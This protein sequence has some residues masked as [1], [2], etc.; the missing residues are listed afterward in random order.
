MSESFLS[1]EEVDAL[2]AA[3]KAGP[4]TDW[5]DWSLE[6]RNA[7]LHRARGFGFDNSRPRDSEIEVHVSE[8]PHWLLRFNS[9]LNIKENNAHQDRG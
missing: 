6:L 9:H 1:Q 2:L 7:L 3:Q 8:F 4:P 5:L